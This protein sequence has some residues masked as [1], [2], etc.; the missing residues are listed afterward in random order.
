MWCWWRSAVGG[1]RPGRL[2]VAGA[3]AAIAGLVLLA[4]LPG[5]VQLSP[6]GIMWVL[7]EAV[8]LA[9]YFLLSA[10]VGDAVLPPLVMAWDG[11]SV[12]TIVLAAAREPGCCRSR[13]VQAM[14]RSCTT[15]SAGSCRC[16]NCRWWQR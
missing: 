14:S 2:T 9:V 12:S 8:S 3:A 10:V 7:G 13:P 4:G 16:W 15:T 11:L 1:Q 6:A 5:S